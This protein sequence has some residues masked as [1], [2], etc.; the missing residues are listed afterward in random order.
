MYDSKL[1]FNY[2][3]FIIYIVRYECPICACIPDISPDIWY[4]I[5]DMKNSHPI[6]LWYPIFRTL[7]STDM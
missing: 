7:V 5:S 1:T 6:R 3:Y 2:Q 4:P